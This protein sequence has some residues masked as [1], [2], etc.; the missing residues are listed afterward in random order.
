[1]VEASSKSV[2]NIEMLLHKGIQTLTE[3]DVLYTNADTKKKRQIIGSIF[4]EKLAFDGFQYRTARLNSVASLIFK[5]GEG[6][7]EKKIGEI[8]EKINF[9]WLVDPYGFEP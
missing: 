4:P 2:M 1:M 8:D 5:L 3:L 6:F 9:S 7:S